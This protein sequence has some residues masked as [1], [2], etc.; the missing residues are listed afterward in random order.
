V[1]GARVFSDA[2]FPFEHRF[3]TPL[4]SS[5][6]SNFTVRARAIDTGGN[7]AWSDEITVTLTPDMTPPRVVR[8]FPALSAI[9]G[10]AGTLAAYFNEPIDPTSL[11]ANTFAVTFAGSD[12]VLG[13]ADDATVN[14]GVISYRDTLN[15]AFLTSATSL[16]PGLYRASVNPPVADVAGNI[17][18]R[19]YSWQFW[20]WKHVHFT[21]LPELRDERGVQSAGQLLSMV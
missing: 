9:M 21:A 10:A 20:V 6:R 5:G 8:T 17:M 12:G 19:A 4:L 16:P 7:F 11:S 3:L 1:D 14:D 15:A 2:S 18:I 13:N